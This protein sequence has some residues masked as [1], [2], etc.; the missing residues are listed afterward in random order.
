[1]SGFSI[2]KKL[3]VAFGLIFIFIS[4]FGLFLLFSFNG[5]SDERSNVRD[6]LD[7][8]VAVSKIN[9]NINEIQRTL[10]FRVLTF[11][12]GQEATLKSRQAEKIK[13]VDELFA[14]YQQVLNNCTYEN[15][16][17]KIHDR[18]MIDEEKKLWQ[19]YKTQLEKIDALIS[20]NNRE[21]SIENLDT[22]TAAF[23]EIS[24]LINKDVVEC[25]DGMEKAVDTSEKNFSDFETL[26][27]VMGIIIAVILIFVVGILILLAKDINNSV[28]KIVS[29]TE[30][31]AQGDLSH[32]IKT[33][34]TDEFGTISEQINSVLQH[35]R[36]VIGKVQN[37]SQ[38]VSESS[39]TM[40]GRVH[41][42]GQLLEDVAMTVTTAT[43]HTHEQKTALQESSE[44]IKK[45]E[46]S[47]TQ[48]AAATQFGLEI[49]C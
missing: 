35:M 42:T 2:T 26:V 15:E 17:E 45:I 20:A 29:V 21:G 43:D 27:H 14:T 25:A 1:M 44:H 16:E 41:H 40:K 5:L 13:T 8:D 7:S 33:D 9:V 46:E 47:V 6:W 24:D 30:K 19:N 12:S 39:Q 22:V 34:S 4:A 3:V 37:A 28:T 49:Q 11:G 36:K 48:S 23:G 31:A 32:D 38:E 18:Q 10:Y